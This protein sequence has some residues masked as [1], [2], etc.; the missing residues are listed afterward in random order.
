M[1]AAGMSM[2]MAM[3]NA[4]TSANV[5]NQKENKAES[6][7]S[8]IWLSESEIKEVRMESGKSDLDS[9]WRKNENNILQY[10]DEEDDN[11]LPK[12]SMFCTT[13]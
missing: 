10:G 9:T 1:T 5:S 4:R 11:S 6:G 13:M 7:S 3:I 2:H 8:S 12:C